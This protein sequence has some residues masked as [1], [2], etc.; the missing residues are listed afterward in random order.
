MISVQGARLFGPVVPAEMSDPRDHWKRRG[1]TARR[2]SNNSTRDEKARETKSMVGKWMAAGALIGG[3]LLVGC[4]PAAGA[5]G[6]ER[7]ARV[8][9]QGSGAFPSTAGLQTRQVEVSD[10]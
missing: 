6:R 9:L 3:I 2:P 5:S 4:F 10:G 8:A 1:T 7:I